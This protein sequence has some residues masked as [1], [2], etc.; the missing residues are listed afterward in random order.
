MGARHPSCMNPS[1]Q[2]ES[3]FVLH[4]AAAA[5]VVAAAEGDT[6]EAFCCCS[7]AVYGRLRMLGLFW[8]PVVHRC[9]CIKKKPKGSVVLGLVRVCG[10]SS[11]GGS[12]VDRGGQETV[13]LSPL[14]SESLLPQFLSKASPKEGLKE[15]GS[16]EGGAR[17]Q[18]A[19]P[20]CVLLPRS[21]SSSSNSNSNSSSSKALWERRRKRRLL[22]LPV[23]CSRMQLLAV[24]P[25]L[26]F[27]AAAA[28]AASDACSWALP[29]WLLLP[30][31][32]KAVVLH[33]HQE[34]QQL[35]Q[36][37]HQQQQQEQQQQQQQ[38]QQHAGASSWSDNVTAAKSVERTHANST[39]SNSSSSSSSSSST[40]A[41]S[42]TSSS[43]SSS[44]DSS[45]NTIT[46][47][48]MSSSSSS[49]SS[50]RGI[51]IS[52]S[53]K[54]I[55]RLPRIEGE[56]GGISLLD[57][58]RIQEIIDKDTPILDWKIIQGWTLPENNMYRN[59]ICRLGGAG[60]PC[61]DEIGLWNYEDYKNWP[62]PIYCPTSHCC[63]DFSGGGVRCNDYCGGGGWTAMHGDECS[64]SKQG[65]KCPE[66]TVCNDSERG[67]YGGAWC[68]CKEGYVGDGFTCY[69]DPCAS[70]SL[71]KCGLGECI[72]RP[73]GA[74]YCR[75]PHGYTW[76]G[77]DPYSP[78]CVL[79]D[80]C[81]DDPCGPQEAVLQCRTDKALE[82]TC[83]C[84]PGYEVGT[85]DGLKRCIVSDSRTKCS[86]EPCGTKGLLSCTDTPTGAD[87]L[88]QK[89]Y[90]LVTEK[91]AKSCMYAPCE[92]EPCGDATA[93]KTC[94]AGLSTYTC[95][96]NSGYK[97]ETQDGLPV[98][99]RDTDNY[100]VILIAG[101]AA[102]V[103]LLITLVSCF[104]LR[105]RLRARNAFES[106]AEGNLTDLMGMQQ[107][108]GMGADA[109]YWM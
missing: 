2:N 13:A 104:I 56:V 86:D 76:D 58:K 12:L 32:S 3:L 17:S 80:M 38:Q 39:S 81:A 79:E 26:L 45:T 37:Q 55:S 63:G 82:Y 35:H 20:A 100:L 90:R 59:Y 29:A 57:E 15:E 99:V 10:Y 67:I 9:A 4:A 5:A 108:T 96:C 27:A 69:P 91:R 16:E 74:A 61:W 101:G 40:S 77:R 11:P 94:T 7:F 105:R 19:A 60:T 34:Q 31:V 30:A 93:V 53:S 88:C 48:S 18:L 64:C 106:Y 95:T 1:K 47:S 6:L 78:K 89:D 22:L 42:S 84:R 24:S 83:V 21:S 70:K 49:S 102:G 8:G 68:Q 98:C 66:N 71:N 92:S 28:T 103:G 65:F 25:L 72:G 36:H 73:N 23:S 33:Q 109:S 97:L 51:D 44:S 85:V 43:T 46:G 41:S 52:L 50:S 107:N 54:D 62:M 14:P 75:C 87:C